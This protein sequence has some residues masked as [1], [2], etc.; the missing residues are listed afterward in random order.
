[1]IDNVVLLI[2]GTLHERNPEELREKCHPLGLFPTM[3][4]ITV[5]QTVSGLYNE[6]LIDTPL[7]MYYF[8]R[9]HQPNGYFLWRS[10]RDLI[11]DLSAS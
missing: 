8:T 3:S 11:L 9:Y 1:M 2:T 4:T 5:E 6:V 7:G 10:G